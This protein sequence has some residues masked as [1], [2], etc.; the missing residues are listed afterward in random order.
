MQ[1]EEFLLLCSWGLEESWSLG[2][3]EGCGIGQ[4][5][6]PEA[7]HHG[8]AA[9]EHT[10]V[11]DFVWRCLKSPPHHGPLGGSRSGIFSKNKDKSCHF[12][13]S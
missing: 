6:T 10:L 7:A 2:A 13:G 11:L 8:F 3:R 4:K 1:Y 5:M 12:N 9:L